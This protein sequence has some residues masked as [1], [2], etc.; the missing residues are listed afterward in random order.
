MIFENKTDK[1]HQS[2]ESGNINKVKSILKKNPDLINKKGA[3]GL[4]PLHKS[5]YMGQSE[6][7]MFLIDSGADLNCDA[8]FESNIRKL[9]SSKDPYILYDIRSVVPHPSRSMDGT[10]LYLAI[11]MG[12]NNIAKYIIDHNVDINKESPQG[13]TP[14]HLS[15]Y[16]WNYDMTETLLNKGA[17]ITGKDSLGLTPLHIAVDV[18]AFDIVKLFI[19]RKVD[20]N[21]KGGLDV[22]PL[23]IASMRG[24]PKIAEL[25]LADNA[26]INTKFLSNTPFH[27]VFDYKIIEDEY[28][29]QI[30]IVQKVRT[31]K[32]L[33]KYGVNINEQNSNG[34]TPLHKAVNSEVRDFVRLLIEAGSAIDVK[35]NDGKTPLD[36]ANEKHLTEIIE[37][38]NKGKQSTLHL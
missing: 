12:Q 29:N 7:S 23:H 38:L 18:G 28:L 4:T 34:W 20:V 22:T 31:A 14:L 19:D 13:W 24:K 17:M 37:I 32:V 9:N 5:I 15:A 10:P 30:M 8:I 36:L 11:Y 35:D 33:L 21:I 1:L 3:F 25:L 26:D 6:I 27:L 16:S 2:I